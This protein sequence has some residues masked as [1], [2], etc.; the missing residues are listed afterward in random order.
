MCNYRSPLQEGGNIHTI[1]PGNRSPINVFSSCYVKDERRPATWVAH[2]YLCTLM[3]IT[4]TH[5][6]GQLEAGHFA[7]TAA[8]CENSCKPVTS[9]AGQTG[10]AAGKLP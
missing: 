1:M 9:G 5:D 6:E 10:W 4:V 2:R 7:G 8:C 3:L